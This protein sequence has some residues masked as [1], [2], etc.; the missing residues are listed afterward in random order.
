MEPPPAPKHMPYPNTPVD[1]L[2]FFEIVMFT[3]TTAATG[4][5]FIQIYRSVWWL[6]H[7]YTHHAMNFY[8]IDIHL[9][10]FILVIFARRLMY[11]LGCVAPA[12]FH[13]VM[14]KIRV[15]LLLAIFGELTLRSC[16]PSSFFSKYILS[17]LPG[18]YVPDSIWSDN[19]SIIYPLFE[20][21][22]ESQVPKNTIS[23]LKRASIPPNQN[24]PGPTRS[25]DAQFAW[26]QIIDLVPMS[27]N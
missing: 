18:I 15:S 12:K 25:I 2:L 7:K 3:I 26:Q 1:G 23:N 6:P 9:V 11:M 4:L 22:S 16:M 8:L 27:R 10:M 19:I 17:L 5:Q 13:S 14:F 21:V 20:L 24:S